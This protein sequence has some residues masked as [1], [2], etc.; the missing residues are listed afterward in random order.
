MRLSWWDNFMLTYKN[1]ICY[2]D[3]ITN[4]HILPLQYKKQKVSAK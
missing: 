2:A 4:L 1:F 3:S